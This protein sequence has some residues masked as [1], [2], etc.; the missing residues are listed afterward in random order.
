MFTNTIEMLAFSK[1]GIEHIRESV[2]PHPNEPGEVLDQGLFIRLTVF[3]T[4]NPENNVVLMKQLIVGDE[5]F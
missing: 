4:N 5:C 2:V 1:P 3:F